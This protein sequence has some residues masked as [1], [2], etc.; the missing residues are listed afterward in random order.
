V[1]KVPTKTFPRTT[2]ADAQG[3]HLRLSQRTKKQQF[4]QGPRIGVKG[5]ASKGLTNWRR[6]ATGTSGRV[7]GSLRPISVKERQPRENE[8]PVNLPVSRKGVKPSGEKK[9]LEFRG[10]AGNLPPNIFTDGPSWKRRRNCPH[11]LGLRV[12]T[13][14]HVGPG[15]RAHLVTTVC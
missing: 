14:N 9:L 11:P 7:P 2:P 4:G 10:T 12:R 6:T 15:G 8:L 5:H 13:T 1:W 3:D